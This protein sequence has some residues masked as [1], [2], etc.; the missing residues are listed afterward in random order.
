MKKKNLMIV[1][2][3][4]LS[5]VGCMFTK[6]ISGRADYANVIGAK[7]A[8]NTDCY[9]LRY[10][11]QKQSILV[12]SP[13]RVRALP[14]IVDQQ[15]INHHFGMYII[16]GVLKKGTAFTIVGAEEEKSPVQT[17]VYL[18][19]KFEDS[20]FKGRIFDVFLLTDDTKSPP[21]FM[22]NLVSQLSN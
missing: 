10:A 9:A 4:S 8:L 6:D 14:E 2:A 1:V 18:K 12:G 16:L 19:A 7:Y 3:V 22:T 15:Y 11:D 21:V 20:S 13:D 17:S 5:L